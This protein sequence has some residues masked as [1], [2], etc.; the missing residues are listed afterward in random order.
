[1]MSANRYEPIWPDGAIWNGH[2]LES[3]NMITRLHVGNS[4]SNR[5]DDT[6]TLMAKY[7]RERSLGVLAGQCV[8]I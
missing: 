4:F 7:N 2:I 8:G 1:M 3:D 5:L 6:S